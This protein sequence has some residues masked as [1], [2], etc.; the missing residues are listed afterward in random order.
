MTRNLLLD[1]VG[2]QLRK[3]RPKVPTSFNYKILRI[4][5]LDSGAF[6][7]LWIRTRGC[8]HDHRGG[9]TICDYWISDPP[10]AEE[11]IQYCEQA[12]GSLDFLPAMI[13]LSVSGSV[14]DLWEVPEQAL[15]GILQLFS[16]SE[17]TRHIL[18]TRADTV[19]ERQIHTCLESLEPSKLEIAMGLE[20]ADPWIL[21]YLRE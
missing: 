7:Q 17:R 13:L 3:R 20:S 9:C 15:Q 14:L 18:E 4:D 1:T 11:I 19:S 10:S 6:V 16:R 12:I 8:R 5:G 21:K 2:L